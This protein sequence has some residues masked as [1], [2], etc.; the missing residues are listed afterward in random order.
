MGKNDTS[1]ELS[2]I[3]L[4]NKFPDDAA[5]EA[6]FVERRW[7]AKVDCP[8]CFCDDVQIGTSHPDMPYRCRDCRKFFSVKTD[9]IMHGSKLGY[10]VWAIALYMITTRPK[11]VSSV[12]LAK[13]LGITQKSAW[14]LL[15]RI[16]ET[17][18]YEG[19]QL[20]G[21]V[22]VDEAYIGGKEKN[23]HS[24]KKL[25]GNWR[26]GKTTVMGARER[27]SGTVIA[28]V[29]DRTDI[30][31]MT[32]FVRETVEVAS[33]VYTDE[34]RG[35]GGLWRFYNHGSVAHYVGQ[36]VDGD[37]HTNGIE[38]FWALLKRGHYGTHHWMSRKHLHR[39]VN[40]FATR[41]NM[42]RMPTIEQMALIARRMDGIK[43]H[44]DDLTF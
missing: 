5:A 18:E 36:Y 20:F 35:Y 22:E 12:Q 30:P 14:F 31:T 8:K 39:Y 3:E 40:E 43:L 2:L 32:R 41:L 7:P 4:F 27:G 28:K 38:S 19:D 37:V 25:H 9:T 17:M 26:A 21:A 44:Y 16:R 33:E 13:D 11:G 10:R 34:H 6:W 24:K 42:K 15:H 29:V 23:K 1:G